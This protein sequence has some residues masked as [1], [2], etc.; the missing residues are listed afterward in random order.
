MYFMNLVSW[1]VCLVNMYGE[2]NDIFVEMNI[3]FIYFI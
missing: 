3:Y 2:L 1:N